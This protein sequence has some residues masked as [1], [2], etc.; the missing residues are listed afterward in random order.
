MTEVELVLDARADLGEGPVWDPR[1]QRLLWVDILVG[2]V[3]AFDPTSG[4]DDVTEVGQSVGCLA[5]GDGG[6]LVLGVRD[7][8]AVLD[9][10]TGSVTM[11]AKVEADRRDNRMNDGACDPA[12]RFWA[13]TMHLGEVP[14]A[15]ALYRLN[16][17]HTVTRMIDDVTISNGIVWCADGS[18]MYFI[19]SPLREVARFP[20]DV[21]SGLLG[22]RERAVDVG[23]LAPAIPDGMAIDEDDRLWVAMWNGGC[24]RCYTSGGRLVE[25]ISVPASKVTSCTFGGSDLNE[26]YITSA[27]RELSADALQDEPLAGGVFRCRPGARGREPQ[28]WAG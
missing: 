20:F 10:E 22:A 6:E 24:V 1:E 26:L 16:S 27:R 15:G 14:R 3:H 7:G 2:H 12:G 23:E 28:T 5:V 21:E 13:G 11:L 18:T 9:L 25:E 17:D 8:F 19:D 4:R